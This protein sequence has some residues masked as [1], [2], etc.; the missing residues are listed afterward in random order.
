MTLVGDVTLLDRRKVLTPA[1]DPLG[2]RR[3][4]PLQPSTKAVSL[5]SP[6][7]YSC[8]CG[9]YWCPG[10][11]K[12]INPYDDLE[13]CPINANASFAG[14]TE[15]ACADD[16]LC[17]TDDDCIFVWSDVRRPIKFGE[18]FVDVPPGCKLNCTG[19][20]RSRCAE[21][22]GASMTRYEIGG[23]VFP[24]AE[25]LPTRSQEATV[26][27]ATVVSYA[28]C[29]FGGDADSA[30]K[31]W[32]F[33]RGKCDKGSIPIFSS[34]CADRGGEVTSQ[35]V[36]I[37]WLSPQPE[38]QICT[39][40]DKE[41]SESSYYS[42]GCGAQSL[43]ESGPAPTVGPTSVGVGGLDENGCWVGTKWCC[44]IDGEMFV[45]P[46]QLLYVKGRCSSNE[47]CSWTESN[48]TLASYYFAC[49]TDEFEVPSGCTLD[50]T[51]CETAP[52]NIDGSTPTAASNPTISPSFGSTPNVGGLDENGCWVG[53]EWCPEL[54]KCI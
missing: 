40:N 48:V 22:G 11:G 34:Y 17:A 30:C 47:K 26:P 51:G 49:I 24:G 16:S 8:C 53:T 19:C 37:S 2:R 38:Y 35:N 1:N 27:S 18:N 32:A 14:P 23:A 5:R 10:L 25:V 31:K 4:P 20:E 44:P 6:H 50:C 12:C 7:E 15:L 29:T 36:N 3:P 41:C 43:L 45:G 13:P 28:L 21:D 9:A 54:E 42:G 52:G 33:Q 46:A 39:I